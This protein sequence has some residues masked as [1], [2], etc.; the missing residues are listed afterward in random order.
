MSFY[1][2]VTV[3]RSGKGLI[4]LGFGAGSTKKAPLHALRF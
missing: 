4:R 1:Q 2:T 3:N